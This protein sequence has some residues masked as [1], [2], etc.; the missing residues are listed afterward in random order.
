MYCGCFLCSYL[1]SST[2]R[3]FTGRWP[4]LSH[5]FRSWGFCIQLISL[6]SLISSLHLLLGLPLRLCP[7]SGIHSCYSYSIHLYSSF[8]S[9]NSI[10][11]KSFTAFTAVYFKENLLTAYSIANLWSILG[12][13]TGFI[14]T[15]Y[16]VV[17]F[18][19]VVLMVSLFLGCIGYVV[20]E[21][22]RRKKSKSSEERDSLVREATILSNSLRGFESHFE[23]TE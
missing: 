22:L 2:S 15:N 12:S 10:F 14:L 7:F 18:H 20:V 13:F 5:L 4:P 9:S 16:V 6:F 1:S 17:R 3:A 21:Y 23:W 19:I 8:Y 11:F